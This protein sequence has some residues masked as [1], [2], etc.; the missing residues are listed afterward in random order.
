MI[1]SL[2]AAAGI[3]MIVATMWACLVA[4]ARMD[5]QFED[6]YRSRREEQDGNDDNKEHEK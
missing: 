3:L 6:F 5:E 4:G 1:L 2:T